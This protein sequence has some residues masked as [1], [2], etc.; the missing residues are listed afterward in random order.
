VHAAF[1]GWQQG[2]VEAD[3][4]QDGHLSLE[5]LA[6]LLKR[7]SRKDQQTLVEESEDE[8]AASILAG[9]DSDRN[10]KISMNELLDHIGGN[11][12]VQAAF[13]GWEQGFQ[14]ADADIDGELD[15]K[16]LSSLLQR[17]SRKDQQKLV[18]ESEDEVAA[19]VLAGFDSDRNGQISMRELVDRIGGNKEVNAAFKGWQQ[20]F[21]EADANKDGQLNV[22]E[23]SSLLQ[24]VSR[25]DQEELVEES[26]DKVAASVLAG[27]DSDRN[28]QISIYELMEH[29]G[30]NK[31]VQA[32]F[33]GWQQGFMEADAN[34]DGQLSLTELS[35]LLQRVSRK[36]QQQLLDDSEDEIAASVIDGFDSDKNG[37][38]SL[39]ELLNRIGEDKDVNA[40]FK[41]WHQGF[42][43]ADADKDGQLDSKE[44]SA[45]LK[46]VSA[47]DQQ[48]LVE[49]SDM[50]VAATVLD[51]FDADRDGKLSLLELL[52]HVEKVGVTAKEWREG[53]KKADLDNDM[54]LTLE[55]LASLFG[56]V[57]RK[58]QKEL[59]EDSEVSIAA[60]L[61]QKI[62]T[63]GDGL[64][65]FQEMRAH[66]PAS[67]KTWA[68]GFA[69][70]DANQDGMLNAQELTTIIKS[71]TKS[72][73]HGMVPDSVEQT[74]KV[75]QGFDAN[76]DGKLSMPEI[77]KHAG[78]LAE[79]YGFGGWKEGF[80][81]HDVDGDKLLDFQELRSL[82]DGVATKQEL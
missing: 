73:Q 1:K 7:I 79:S 41:G 71:L 76:G 47:K 23:L 32:A 65:S 59:V 75:L 4:N 29:V 42:V 22:K 49:E 69:D 54:H 60:S 43:E 19:S 72:E 24:R 16:E 56:R 10:G 25:K 81:K 57:S 77:A 28:G 6:G 18:E 64:I 82:L 36:D 80:I 70:A 21:M 12:E 44:L 45:L 13:K 20:G 68:Q 8:V 30:K 27:F 53:F 34:K 40:A 38:I 14:E 58:D 39:R 63:D 2:F 52:D 51:G 61:L 74:L 37:K 5:E 11:R 78:M 55:E 15:V 50:S 26:E 46:R 48:N 17:V 31:E 67:A 3:A 62:D 33:K 66:L 9:F 35:A